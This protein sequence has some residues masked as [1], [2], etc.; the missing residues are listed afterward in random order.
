MDIQRFEEGRGF[1]DI[2]IL[3]IDG[4]KAMQRRRFD[5]NRIL[6]PPDIGLTPSDY[7][8]AVRI[9]LD[10]LYPWLKPEEVSVVHN[11]R[12]ITAVKTIAKASETIRWLEEETPVS[13]TDEVPTLWSVGFGLFRVNLKRIYGKTNAFF[14]KEGI[15]VGSHIRNR[16][17]LASIYGHEKRHHWH[18]VKFPEFFYKTDNMKLHDYI[19]NRLILEADAVAVQ[20]LIQYELKP[21]SEPLSITKR[22]ELMS[23]AFTEFI[24][25]VLGAIVNIQDTGH[26]RIARR[27]NFLTYVVNPLAIFANT[28]SAEVDK[29]TKDIERLGCEKLSTQ[30][31]LD[32]EEDKDHPIYKIRILSP[33]NLSKLKVSNESYLTTKHMHEIRKIMTAHIPEAMVKAVY[34]IEDVQRRIRGQSPD[35]RA[36]ILSN[37][38]LIRMHRRRKREVAKRVDRSVF[39]RHHNPS[40]R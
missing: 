22:N 3:T 33:E 9:A 15:L 23:E 10:Q 38:D 18:S 5:L 30:I 32:E 13:Q 27:S 12:R 1:P 6:R 29:L 31:T 16:R 11:P 40:V 37:Q 4:Q 17:K 20:A 28:V 25:G 39:R 34:E 2:D 21:G 7:E 35:V 26:N 14:T 19:V 24:Y 8:I 36:T